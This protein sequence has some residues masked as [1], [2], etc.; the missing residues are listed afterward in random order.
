MEASVSSLSQL[1]ADP[2][3]RERLG[4]G[5]HHVLA[6]DETRWVR[7]NGTSIWLISGVKLLE[8]DPDGND[9]LEVTL[10][11]VT[12]QKALEDQL[13]QG[14]KMELLGQLT[15][16][17]IH[18]FNN[19]LAT[20]L[21]HTELLED[22]IRTGRTD[23]ALQ[24]LRQLRV[25]AER[26]THMIRH[27]LVF[28]RPEDL[29]R[30]RISLNEVVSG[31]VELLRRLLPQTIE[32][33]MQEE[34][35]EL[36]ALADPGAIQ[37]ILMNLATNAR[38]AMPRGGRLEIAVVRATLDRR[39]M[40]QHGW[41]Q[42]GEYASIEVRDTGVGMAPDVMARVFEPFFTTKEKGKGTGLGLPMVYGLMKQHRGFVEVTAAEKGGTRVRLYFR[43]APDEPRVPETRTDD[44]TATPG[45]TPSASV[46][47]VEDDEA[48]RKVMERSLGRAG[49]TVLTARDG[50]EALDLLD[51][52]ERPELII[53]DV[54]MPGMG[55]VEL[56][57]IL[58]SAGGSSP[59]VLLTSGL[60]PS[61][62]F[63]GE[64]VPDHVPF[65]QKPWTIQQ[66][67]ARVSEI[68]NGRG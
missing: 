11:D 27:L 21:T 25:T 5:V 58:A 13:R 33:E 19:I 23:E 44:A 36:H 2:L 56:Q 57:K 65:L 62:A 15:G 48:L 28:S 41:G 52:G 39:H 66:L 35:E 47:L 18:D 68:L 45:E 59:P 17:V 12:E 46:L 14:Q 60:D 32:I 67:Q 63:Q 6:G 8:W 29:E 24:D 54:V 38:D 26:G 10:E 34:E 4:E 55:G 40:N 61:R 37:Q 16:G 50:H 7:R 30:N 53:A 43:P 9:L 31:T 22:G 51:A 20:I 64:P 1:L 49:Y 3:D 42:P